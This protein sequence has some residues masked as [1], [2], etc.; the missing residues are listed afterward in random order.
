MVAEC[1]SVADCDAEYVKFVYTVDTNC[2]RGI[3]KISSL[4]REVDNVA[5]NADSILIR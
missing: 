4:S 5:R 3:Q 1:K 2:C